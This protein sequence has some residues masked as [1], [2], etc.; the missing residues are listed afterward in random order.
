MP[1]YPTAS[2]DI[3]S[4]YAIDLPRASALPGESPYWAPLSW[5]NIKGRSGLQ[6]W[7]NIPTDRRQRDT[8]VDHVPCEDDPFLLDGS[9]GETCSSR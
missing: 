5:A 3:Q 4:K 2:P 6:G 9:E 8:P 1:C 7:K